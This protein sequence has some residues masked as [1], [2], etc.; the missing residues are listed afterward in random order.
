[1][2]IVNLGE[3]NGQSGINLW[4]IIPVASN[5]ASGLMSVTA[6]LGVTLGLFIA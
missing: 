4:P 6:I 3:G 5:L 2:K 1:M